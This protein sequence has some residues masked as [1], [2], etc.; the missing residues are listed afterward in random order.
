[1][2]VVDPLTVAAT[3]GRLAGGLASGGLITVGLVILAADELPVDVPGAV[4]TG[5]VVLTL[6]VILFRL[7]LQASKHSADLSADLERRLIARNEALEEDL[8]AERERATRLL[9]AWEAER[10][11]RIQLRNAVTGADWTDPGT[12]LA[13]LMDLADRLGVQVRKPDTRPE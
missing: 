9:L 11:A 6:G 4:G 3:A 8:S 1:M 10:A 12:D 2:A 5:A 7:V 13:K